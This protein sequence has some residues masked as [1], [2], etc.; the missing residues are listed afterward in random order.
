MQSKFRALPTNKEIITSRPLACA[1]RA[2]EGN[3]LA[4]LKCR[5]P[6]DTPASD[7]L[8]HGTSGAR[9]EV[10]TLAERK[11]VAAAKVKDISYIER[12]QAVVTLD[13]ETWNRRSA[14]ALQ[15]ASVEQV[16]S[17]RACLGESVSGQEIQPARKLLLHLSLQGMV[18]GKFVGTIWLGRLEP[19]KDS[20]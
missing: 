9:Q 20:K 16:A 19:G 12:S 3:R 18:A 1:R 8:V 14:V 15:A 10:L 17:V 4:A 7:Q 5:D 11:L 6:V 13:S 2:I